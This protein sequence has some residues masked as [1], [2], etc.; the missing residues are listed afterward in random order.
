MQAWAQQHEPDASLKL[1]GDFGTMTSLR[2]RSSP[3][4]GI[5]MMSEPELGPTQP[6]SLLRIRDASDA[7]SWRTFVSIYAPLIYRSCRRRELQDADAADVGQEVLLDC[8]AGGIFGR[9]VTHRLRRSRLAMAASR[10][11]AGLRPST[12]FARR[13]AWSTRSTPGFSRRACSFGPAWNRFAARC[14]AICWAITA[15]SF[16]SDATTPRFRPTSP[17]P[18]FAWAA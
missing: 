1:P 10:G 9:R 4:M 16:G 7:E 15:T 8:R 6:S 17:R 5:M 12:T 3:L 18:A 14:S 11:R 2:A 13:A